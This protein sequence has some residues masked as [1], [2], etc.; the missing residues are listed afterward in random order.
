V[1]NCGATSVVEEDLHIEHAAMAY[2]L[3]V[4]PM[5]RRLVQEGRTLVGDTSQEGNY[6]NHREDHPLGHLQVC[7]VSS[8]GPFVSQ[9]PFLLAILNP[10]VNQGLVM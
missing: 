1:E 6:G 4:A 5:E 9:L 7:G 2:T 10:V 8:C 3:S